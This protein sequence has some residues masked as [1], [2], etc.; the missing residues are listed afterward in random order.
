MRWPRRDQA[1]Q[2]RADAGAGELDQAPQ[3]CAAAGAIGAGLVEAIR[4]AQLAR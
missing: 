2:L 1:E 3:I 4:A